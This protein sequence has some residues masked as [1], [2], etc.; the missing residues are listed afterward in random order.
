VSNSS[1]S[2][3]N[4]KHALI[5]FIVNDLPSTI[6]SLA[7]F[8]GGIWILSLRIP[9]WSLLWGL[10]LTP[11]GAALTV[12]TLDKVSRNKIAPPFFQLTKCKVCGRKTY[13]KEGEK[14]IVCGHCRKDI[15]K[16]ILK[17]RSK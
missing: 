17:E 11:T 6:L 8:L 14:G 4:L 12:F 10:I 13:S 3:V 15:L 7:L 9:G 1:L 5:Q 16:K 2:I